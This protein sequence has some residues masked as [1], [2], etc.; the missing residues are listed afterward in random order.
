MKGRTLSLEQRAKITAAQRARFARMTPEERNA[1]AARLNTPEIKAGR[2]EQM[3]RRWEKCTGAARAR[4]CAHITNPKA[5][6]KSHAAQRT[7]EFAERRSAWSKRMWNGRTDEER[8]AVGAML[9]EARRKKRMER[10]LPPVA[11]REKGVRPSPV[12]L[13]KKREPKAE[14][15]VQKA[16]KP[17]KPPVMLTYRGET[18]SVAEWAYE[19]K[20]P[21][22]LITNR[23]RMGWPVERIFGEPVKARPRRYLTYRGE[24]RTCNEWARILGI[25][26]TTIVARLK[27]G[28]PVEKVLLK[29][30]I[31]GCQT[32]SSGDTQR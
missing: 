3:L 6:A 19:L 10:G 12:R 18:R 2:H 32:L 20:I 29:G 27:A 26:Q 21:V 14:R 24:T 8:K 22:R 16:V 1:M 17:R 15:Q 31:G 13:R 7:P 28:R 9:A 25:N 5:Q 4:A 23:R 30:R 11:V